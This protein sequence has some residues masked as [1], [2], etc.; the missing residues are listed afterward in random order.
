MKDDFDGLTSR[1]GTADERISELED[2]SV[3]FS[4]TE[5]QGEKKTE[6]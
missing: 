5:K 4:K 6:K 3:E 1:V 2:I